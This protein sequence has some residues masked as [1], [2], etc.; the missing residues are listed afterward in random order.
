M[1]NCLQG[2]FTFCMTRQHFNGLHWICLACILLAITGCKESTQ[3]GPAESG[4]TSATSTTATS[5]SIQLQ[6]LP[7]SETGVNFS[8]T[9]EDEGRINIFTWHFIYNG[10]GVAA[11][12]INNDGLA[13]LYF[14]GN[15][16]PDKL[17]L[18]KGNFQFEDIT[19]TSGI[20]SQVWSSGVTMADVNADGL[21]D[22]Y[23]CRNS[24]TGIHDNNR[25]KLYI[26]QGKNV[27]REQAAQYGIDDF[28][29]STQ[30]T[31]FDADQDGDLDMYLVNQPFDEFARL[32]NKPEVV[33]SYPE[34]DRFFFNENGKFVGPHRT[35]RH[36]RKPLRTQCQHR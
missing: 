32:V 27:F 3:T 9:I 15:Q 28:G 13:D 34:T 20:S 7:A 12:D 33:A 5:A 23:V 22:I 11:G 29:F 10:A 19:N 26:N 24:P 1:V 25:N 36:E 21:L 17:Y 16:T 30:A 8:N 18:N 35:T 31:F 14:T 6:S 4:S 2:L